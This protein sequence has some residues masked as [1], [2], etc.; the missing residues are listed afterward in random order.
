MCEVYVEWPLAATIAE[1][2]EL[3]SLAKANGSKTIVGLQ[4]LADPLVH[5]LK[6]IVQSGKLGKVLSTIVKGSFPWTSAAMWPEQVKFF[7][8]LDS[9]ASIYQVLFGHCE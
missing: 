2:D 7:L 4:S 6:E 5:K 1:A 3:T 9:G 8:L